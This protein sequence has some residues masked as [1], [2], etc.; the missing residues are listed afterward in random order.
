MI[1]LPIT[2]TNKTQIICNGPQGLPDLASG[3]WSIFYLFHTYYEPITEWISFLGLPQQITT[4][5]IAQHNR[6]LFSHRYGGR[7]SKIKVS[8]KLHSFLRAR[9]SVDAS[10]SPLPPGNRSHP[11]HSVPGSCITPGS[12]SD[13]TRPPPWVCLCVQVSLF[14]QGHPSSG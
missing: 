12:A 2:L 10:M 8:A 9:T 14:L 1:N 5:R 6:H 7:K 3:Y 4:N 11:W 13:F